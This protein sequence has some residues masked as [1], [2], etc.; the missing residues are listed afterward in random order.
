M[1]LMAFFSVSGSVEET[2]SRSAVG[3]G[4]PTT[5]EVAAAAARLPLVSGSV[6][7]TED[8]DCVSRRSGLSNGNQAGDLDSSSKGAPCS[9]EDQAGH[10]DSGDRYPGNDGGVQAN[11]E[12]A[13][14]E[15][16]QLKAKP[17]DEEMLK[18]Y[19]LFKQASVGDV[20]TDRPGMFDF[21]GKAKWDA[22]QQQKGK[23]KEDAMNEYIS[24]VEE[25]KNKYGI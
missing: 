2:S 23:S 24:L 13:A 12:K 25:L 17:M 8:G 5:G 14:A 7:E 9:G 15:V 3:C 1:L 18:V 10:S 4:R 16:K 21:T 22:W 6:E 20:N 19:S 11:F